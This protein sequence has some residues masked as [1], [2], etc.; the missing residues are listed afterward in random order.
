MRSNQ[1]WIQW[2]VHDPLFG[3]AAWPGHE[4]GGPRGWTDEAFYAL[5][6]SDWDDFITRWMNYGV[7]TSSCLEIGSGA[8]RLTRHMAMSFG[9]VHAVD[10][11]ADMLDYA[12]NHIH[13]DNV[14][15]HVTNGRDIPMTDNSVAAV[16]STHV[17]Q[18]FDSPLDGTR[19]F[20]EL[21]R[22][23]TEDGTLMIHLPMHSF[24]S[25]AGALCH[26]MRM[27]YYA[28]RKAGDLVANC[29]RLI[30]SVIGVRPT[31]RALS[32]EMGLVFGA[33]QAL[34]FT[35]V[36]VVLFPVRSNGHLHSF[37]LARKGRRTYPAPTL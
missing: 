14:T 23:L 3:V 11:S 19:Y 21:A 20:G 17:F 22:V 37:V 31:M 29:R 10:V 32:Y 9:W 18:H 7:D 6:K 4:R 25:D 16:F 15:Y 12:R 5:G 36:E 24:P 35:D 13:T 33:L 28:R 26:G 8:G 1:D 27:L 2:G 30:S 34:R